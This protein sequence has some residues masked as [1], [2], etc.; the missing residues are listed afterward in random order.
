MEVTQKED[1]Y[2]TEP[3]L[4]DTGGRAC[5]RKHKHMLK[6]A[7]SVRDSCQTFISLKEFVILFLALSLLLNG[8]WIL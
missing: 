6:N 2:L 8:A 3:L 4:K 1:L 5:K 7:I